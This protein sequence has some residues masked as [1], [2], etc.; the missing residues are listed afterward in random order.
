MMFA[1]AYKYNK[2]DRLKFHNMQEKLKIIQLFNEDK[3]SPY[4]LHKICKMGNYYNAKA[5]EYWRPLTAILSL[6]KLM[7]TNV[8]IDGV[9]RSEPEK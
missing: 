4:S 1:V 9:N 5:G 6:G 8:I 2:G 7:C 3:S